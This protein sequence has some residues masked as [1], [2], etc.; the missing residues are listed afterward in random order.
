M[1]DTLDSDKIID[2]D[3][4][5]HN[6]LIKGTCRTGKTYLAIQLIKKLLIAKIPVTVVNTTFTIGR[7]NADYEPI[8]TANNSNYW[9]QQDGIAAATDHL[10][11]GVG[12]SHGNPTHLPPEETISCL[13]SR[14]SLFGG[15]AAPMENR[16]FIFVD[17]IHCIDPKIREF[18]DLIL[19]KGK[20][21][22]IYSVHIS[23]DAEYT[24]P[25][26]HREI[27]CSPPHGSFTISDFKTRAKLWGLDDN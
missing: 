10:L 15:S 3:T 7:I 14:L 20:P 11:F 22:G 18:F 12:L 27:L 25:D 1:N 5:P 26:F 8:F 17:E 6:L 2:I 4:R 21:D 9:H 13:Q 19:K 23:Q 16:S 24:N